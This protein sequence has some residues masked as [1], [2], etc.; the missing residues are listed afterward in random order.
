M[1]VLERKVSSYIG[2]YGIVLSVCLS[3]RS[4]AVRIDT[5]W[6]TGWMD[7]SL[8]GD[9]LAGLGSLKYVCILR[10]DSI[11]FVAGERTRWIPDYR[12]RGML[13][14]NGIGKCAR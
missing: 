12:Y 2:L 5:H 13:D 7:G 9:G 6:Y 1:V 10:N 11:L 8:P 14:S 4:F 3:Q